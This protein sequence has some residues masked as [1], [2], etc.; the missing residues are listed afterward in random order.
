MNHVSQN[1]LPLSFQ[2]PSVG[3]PLGGGTGIL[4]DP[5]NTVYPAVLKDVWRHNKQDVHPT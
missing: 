5:E 1:V 4:A 2:A 3:L